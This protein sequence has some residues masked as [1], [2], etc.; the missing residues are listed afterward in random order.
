M[1]CCCGGHKFFFGCLQ[2]GPPRD[3]VGVPPPVIEGTL[4]LIEIAAGRIFWG[5]QPLF[6]SEPTT[7]CGPLVTL[8]LATHGHGLGHHPAEH[9]SRMSL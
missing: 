8:T 4:E 7:G 3:P 5:S 9:P 1:D 6:K 2:T